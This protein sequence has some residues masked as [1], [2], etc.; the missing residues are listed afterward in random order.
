MDFSSSGQQAGATGQDDAPASSRD[1]CALDERNRALK[2]MILA[3]A[4][5]DV[6]AFEALYDS[7]AAWLLNRVRRITGDAHAEDVLA[8]V[9]LQV[10]RSLAIYDDSR[11]QPL[12]W[13]ATIGRSRALDK[14]RTERRSHGG[15]L[16]APALQDVEDSHDMGPEE[17]LA[18]AERDSLLKLS[19][20]A[21]SPKEQ[22]VLGMAY[23]RDCSQSEIALLTGMPLG[24]VKTLMT[25]SQ[26]KLRVSMGAVARRGHNACS[27]A[28]FRP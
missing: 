8:E 28:T 20:G 26:Q 15:Q 19:M 5:G 25:R 27:T 2:V 13:L 9:Y 4:R 10:W 7:T 16:D 22:L 6:H 3:A 23:F 1:N 12:A 18:I 17:L 24:T 14:L 11:G 21:L